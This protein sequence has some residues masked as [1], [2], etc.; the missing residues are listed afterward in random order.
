MKR[1]LCRFVG[2]NTL[3]ES[4]GYCPIHQKEKELNSKAKPFEYATRSNEGYY[5]LPEWRALKKLKLK[6]M[7]YCFYCGVPRKETRLEVHH[8]IPPRGD[9]DKFLD[10]ENL[11]SVCP[12]CHSRITA[13]EIQQRRKQ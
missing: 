7:P 1:Y 10:Y 9:K 2:C 3:L 12:E 6:E 8:L 5:Q 4:P 13:M 11:V